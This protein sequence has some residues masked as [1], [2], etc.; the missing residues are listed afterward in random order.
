MKKKKT[1]KKIAKRGNTAMQNLSWKERAAAKAKDAE[2]NLASS[3]SNK[4]S[5]R[6]GDLTYG[7]AEIE[8]PFMC[9][10]LGIG[11]WKQYF[12]GKFNPDS[13]TPAG[14][15]AIGTG[16]D[17]TSLADMIPSEN[18]PVVQ[19]ED[20]VS[21]SHNEFGPNNE[22][23]ECRDSILLAVVDANDLDNLEAAEVMMLSV[24]PTSMANFNA[25]NKKC[26]KIHEC[27]TY[28]VICAITQGT[29]RSGS[30]TLEFAVEDL[31][32]ED[33]FELETLVA[34]EGLAEEAAGTVL[35]EPDVS[36]YDAM[37]KAAK[38]SGGHRK[39]K[40]VSKKKRGRKS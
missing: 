30:W 15:F 4:I 39:K 17:N 25:F 24:P 11:R 3:A 5:T 10:V 22:A 32:T 28:G 29:G 35:E 23:K 2:A 21:C 34:L 8:Y 31:L 6:N 40:A 38:G 37:I 13:P 14:C 27:P 1:G 36:N 33:D 20:C 12:E 18:S 7:G 26:I 16:L 19:N 9:V